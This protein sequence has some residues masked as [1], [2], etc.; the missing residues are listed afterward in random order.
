MQSILRITVLCTMSTFTYQS[1]VLNPVEGWTNHESIIQ[2]HDK[3]YLF[4]HDILLSRKTHL[5]NIKLTELH[6][7]PDGSIQTITPYKPA[8]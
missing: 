7:N 5:R 3:W 8:Q 2:F 1:V 4:Y 6:Y